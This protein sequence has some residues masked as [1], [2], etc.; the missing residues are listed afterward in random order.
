LPLSRRAFSSSARILK[1]KG[2]D[3][4]SGSGG[5]GKD[6]GSGSS[7]SSG[8]G[9]GSESGSAGSGSGASGS[10]GSGSGNGKGGSDRKV[11]KFTFDVGSGGPSTNILETGLSKP[12]IPEVYPQVLTLPIGRRPLFPG[13]YKAV[14]IKNP[15][16][17]NAIKELMKR[18]QPYVGAFLLKDEDLDIDTVTSMDQI[19]SVGVFAQ[20]TT[21]FPASAGSDEGSIT[22]VLY[23]HR[24]IKIKELLPP[25]ILPDGSEA[26]RE[27]LLVKEAGEG[28]AEK[29]QPLTIKVAD[30]TPAASIIPEATSAVVDKPTGAEAGAIDGTS[31][32]EAAAAAAASDASKD[33]QHLPTAFLAKEY[34]VTLSNVENMV[35]EPYN[36]KNQVIRA[37]TS[38]IVA[39]FKDIASLNPLFRDQIANFSMSQSAGN[40]FEEPA[41]LADFATAVSQ[42]DPE[43]LQSVLESLSIEDRMQKALLVLKKELMNAQLQSKI[44]KDVEN[45]IAKRQREYYLME[46]LKG[47]KKELGIE[48]DG[49]DKLIEKFREKGIKLAMPEQVKKVFDEVCAFILTSNYFPFAS[50][51]S[52]CMHVVFV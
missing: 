12:A 2:D 24:R 4:K 52:D 10:S 15:A 41:K 3:G 28:V 11:T 32:D 17:A 48:S 36:R 20:I 31:V 47:I 21:V 51:R 29:P 23:P 18:G 40:V 50:F 43:E 39:V 26:P 27:G 8:S 22:A 34:A 1:E 16:V 5:D 33:P 9:S 13:F 46:Q 42:G 30:A 45:K 38:E 14:V 19:H 35:D 49:K 25:L 44:S 37:I 7:S 6:S